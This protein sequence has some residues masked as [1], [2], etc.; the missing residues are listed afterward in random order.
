MHELPPSPGITPL[1]WAT[2]GTIAPQVRAASTLS[3]VALPVI[4]G[5]LLWV[6]LFLRDVAL[7]K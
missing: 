6:G 2:T 4:I 7:Q 5:T 3:S 1:D